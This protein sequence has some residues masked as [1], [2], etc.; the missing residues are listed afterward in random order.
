MF[1]RYRTVRKA[2]KPKGLDFALRRQM[3]G[4][5]RRI[6]LNVGGGASRTPEGGEEGVMTSPMLE[7]RLP[8]S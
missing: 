4:V 8:I 3:S 2:S 6:W 5:K 1:F 7:T